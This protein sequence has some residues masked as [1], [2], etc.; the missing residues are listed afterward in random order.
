MLFFEERPDGRPRPGAD[1]RGSFSPKDPD[2]RRRNHDEL[3]RT[4][5]TPKLAREF[6]LQASM[7]RSL[8]EAN[9]IA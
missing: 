5:E 1:H 7:I 6:L 3:R 8:D 9:T 2:V 4:A